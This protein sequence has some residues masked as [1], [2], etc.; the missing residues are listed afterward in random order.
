[1]FQQ[2]D[3]T[4]DGEGRCLRNKKSFSTCHNMP[5][6]CSSPQEKRVNGPDD[7]VMQSGR[8]PAEICPNL[9]WITFCHV[10]GRASLA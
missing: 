7:S 5:E 6:A 3:G 8:D 9:W 4:S 1:M 2:A 10:K